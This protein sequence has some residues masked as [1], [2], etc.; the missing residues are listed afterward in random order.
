MFV[1]GIH[2]GADR[3]PLTSRPA[4]PRERRNFP[5]EVGVARVDAADGK[6]DS[7]SSRVYARFF[8]GSLSS[9]TFAPVASQPMELDIETDCIALS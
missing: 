1:T 5:G 6:S 2:R 4:L 7:A 9:R 8:P 3:T